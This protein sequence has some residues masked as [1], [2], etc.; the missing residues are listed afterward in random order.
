M[1]SNL[2]FI[3]DPFPD[4]KSSVGPCKL[5]LTFSLP[6]LESTLKHISIVISIGP[7][8]MQVIPGKLPLIDIFVGKLENPNAMLHAAAPIALVLSSRKEVVSSVAIDL[9][10]N[11]A[12]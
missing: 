8:S 11:E 9:I 5:S 6:Y 3:V 10:I 7:L 2:E 12:A 1:L 4:L